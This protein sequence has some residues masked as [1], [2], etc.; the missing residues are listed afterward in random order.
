MEN[1]Q[2]V[3]DYF[4]KVGQ[5]GDPRRYYNLAVLLIQGKSYEQ[6][7]A[8]LE[9]VLRMQFNNV[10]AMNKVGGFVLFGAWWQ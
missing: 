10:Q 1:K 8:L 6:A 9:Q 2:K 3:I 4:M 7:R 5:L